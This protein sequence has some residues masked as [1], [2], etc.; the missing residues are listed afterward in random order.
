MEHKSLTKYRYPTRWRTLYMD[1][2]LQKQKQYFPQTINQMTFAPSYLLTLHLQG[3][4]SSW[5]HTWSARWSSSWRVPRA[6]RPTST[7]S[8]FSNRGSTSSIYPSYSCNCSG[9]WQVVQ[10]I[11]GGPSGRALPFVDGMLRRSAMFLSK[12]TTFNLM[13]TRS[14]AWPDGPACIDLAALGL[15]G[16]RLCRVSSRSLVHKIVRFETYLPVGT[17][18]WE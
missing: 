14:S 6:A 9:S 2:L 5:G 17:F 4:P 11:Q 10:N 15:W 1:V 7:S 3:F 12:G 8:S 16:V 13:S 18:H